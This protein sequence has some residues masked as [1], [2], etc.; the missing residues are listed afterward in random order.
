MYVTWEMELFE[1]VHLV[2]DV[3]SNVY[4]FEGSRGVVVI[5]TGV[6]GQA[7]KIASYVEEALRGE[8]SFVIITHSDG[9]HMGSAAALRRLTGASVAVH[10]EEAGILAGREPPL[11]GRMDGREPVVPDLVIH[12]GEEVA[13]LGVIYTPGHTPGHVC[14]YSQERKVL[15]A[16]DSFVTQ[17]NLVLGPS[18]K[19]TL[20]MPGAVE[21][22][23]GLISLPIDVLCPGH[24]PPIT[25]RGGRSVEALSGRCMNLT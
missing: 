12:G 13:G 19:Y 10:S 5:D 20:D 6:A 23:R 9:D 14:L 22:L 21:S 2:D 4:T 3:F 25:E 15:F 8:V 11:K 17:E 7:K 24:G 18:E 16:G 1:G